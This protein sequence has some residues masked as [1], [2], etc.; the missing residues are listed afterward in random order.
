VLAIAQLDEGP[1]WWSQIVDADPAA[2]TVGRLT[3]GF[4]R[5]GPDLEAV[6][7]FGWH[8]ANLNWPSGRPACSRKPSWL[9]SPGP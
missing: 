4:E 9:C 8:E 6:P 2:I 5:A 3:I 7:V 1:W